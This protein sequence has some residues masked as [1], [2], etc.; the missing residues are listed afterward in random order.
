MSYSLVMQSEAIIDIQEAFEWYETQ[1]P[2]L[3]FRLID[4]VE[5]TLEKIC[6]TPYHYTSINQ[7]YRRIKVNRFSYLVIYEIE[8]GKLIVNA[9][10][11]TRRKPKF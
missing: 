2:G 9:V 1:Q 4:E 10:R 11:H 8:G 6:R 5:N 7:Q 3:G